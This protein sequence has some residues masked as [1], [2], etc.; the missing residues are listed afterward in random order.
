MYQEDKC[1]GFIA[2]VI[3]NFRDN[4]ENLCLSE[5]LFQEY[6][7]LVGFFKL[8]NTHIIIPEVTDFIPIDSELHVKLFY[9]GCFVPLPQ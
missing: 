5:Y 8:T 3:K 1:Q 9:K 2:D 7:D 6:D 4:S